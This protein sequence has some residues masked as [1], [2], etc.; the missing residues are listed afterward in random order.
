MARGAS[1]ILYHMGW[2]NHRVLLEGLPGWV[3]KR[4]PVEGTAPNIEPE[5]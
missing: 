4:Y 5:H 1:N 3:A 2:R